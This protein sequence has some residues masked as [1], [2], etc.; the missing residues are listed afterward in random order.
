MRGARQKETRMHAHGHIPA[1]GTQ[2][3]GRR[4]RSG[5]G[6][7]QQLAA[8]WAAHRTARRGATLAALSTC[9]DARDEV[10][11]PPR[12]DAAPEMAAAAL[13]L[14]VDTLLYGLRP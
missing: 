11:T 7:Y 1:W 5:A 10:I 3:G 12:A 6:W 4:A 14:P 8:W 13:A 9:W 2:I